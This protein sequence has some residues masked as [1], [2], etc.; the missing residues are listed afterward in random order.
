MK[1]KKY[2]NV[3]IMHGNVYLKITIMKVWSLK[4]R[5]IHLPFELLILFSCNKRCADDND[6]SCNTTETI[7]ASELM[8][9]HKTLGDKLSVLSSRIVDLEKKETEHLKDLK[10][11]NRDSQRNIFK[12]KLFNIWYDLQNVFV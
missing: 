9:I 11:I 1:K 3:W 2:K 8:K 5:T 12:A 6:N 10:F 7:S 4:P